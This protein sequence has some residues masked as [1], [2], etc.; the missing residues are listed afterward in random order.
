MKSADQSQQRSLFERAAELAVT[1]VVPCRNERDYIEACLRSI[2]GQTGVDGGFEVI[3]VDGMSDDGTREILNALASEFDI[4][5]V[6]E[7]P[8]N[9]TPVAMNIGI[10]AA[11]GAHIAILG[12]HTV[13]ALDYLATCL[14]LL[15]EH[16]EVI[17]AGGPIRSKGKS[18][19]GRAVARAMS[20][21]LGVGNAYH[22]HPDYEGYGEG[23]C[24]P[25]FRREVFERHGLYNEDLARNQDDEFNLRIARA[26]ENIYLSPQASSDYYVRERLGQLFRQYYLY[27][28]F[29]RAVMRIH[30]MPMTLR[31]LAPALFYGLVILMLMLAP[32]LPEWWWPLSIALPVVYVLALMGAGATVCADDGPGVGLR[33]VLAAATMHAAYALGFVR[34]A[35]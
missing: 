34:G 20:H 26:G 10:R 5:S 15:D 22:R 33:F 8:R 13:Y 7:N 17:G 25:L 6:V 9:I 32:F 35:P 24:F 30:G 28:R 18:A 12:A 23:A 14:H 19:F 2:V 4:L 27:G 11:R 31:P 1:V 29:R 3:V 21:P 16:P